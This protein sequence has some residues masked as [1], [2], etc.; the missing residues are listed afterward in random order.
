MSTHL[1]IKHNW[2]QN[3]PEDHPERNTEAEISISLKGTCVTTF[4]DQST[5]KM[6]DSPLLSAYHLAQWLA[7]NWWRL[8]WEPQR[9]NDT[10]WDMSHNTAAAGGGYIWPSI[11]FTS[12]GETIVAQ[13]RATSKTN[14]EPIAYLKDYICSIDCA[15]FEQ[16]LDSFVKSTIKHISHT[17]GEETNL[18]KLW[19]E[20]ERER[21]DP[22]LS[23]V[24]KLEAYL[25]YDP[26]EAPEEL[27]RNLMNAR[28]RY[29]AQAV[30]EIAAASRNLAD[31]RL[32]EL[33]ADLRRSNNTVRMM[34]CTAITARMQTSSSHPPL[35]ERAAQAA[36]VARQVW[37]LPS[38]PIQTETICDL[39]G[40]PVNSLTENS[41]NQPSK[42][43][44]EISAGFREEEQDRFRIVLHQ[45]RETG[46]RFTLA[47]LV[48]DYLTTPEG[49]LLPATAAK[50]S[51]QKF[52]RAFAQ[53][54]LCPF[55]DLMEV[56]N[57]TT[58]G[59]N[60]IEKVSAHFNVSPPIITR[61]LEHKG[62]L[63]NGGHPGMEEKN[64]RAK[65]APA[66]MET[67][68]RHPIVQGT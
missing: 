36:N 63:K 14:G 42:L 8:L 6:G 55:N 40:I 29:G 48:G 10:D 30:H 49:H 26:D 23:E 28:E 41:Q 43:R 61:T 60:D 58:P 66:G 51:R 46:R 32:E 27:I 16:E 5:K 59:E 62:I 9:Q 64:G 57:T 19:S 1:K 39:F 2:M 13:S 53:E 25:G 45:P 11:V 20:I 34:E 54:F 52:Q 50:T 44:G 17:I 47:R 4:L 24:R 12:D 56:L 67:R 65:Q 15:D 37:N 33:N 35:W 22:E 21:L 68:R 38:G 18:N 7:A 31:Q 3:L